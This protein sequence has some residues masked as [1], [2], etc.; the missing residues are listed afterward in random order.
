MAR[1]SPGKAKIII[2]I[3][4]IVSLISACP[5]AIYTKVN[6]LEYNGE[7]LEEASYC[8]VPHNK[9]NWGS[10]YLMLA[11]TVVYFVLPMITVIILFARLFIDCFKFVLLSSLMQTR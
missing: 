4:W 2:V 5:W 9:E 1:S 7:D 3:I 10:L 8:T 11:S 6:Y